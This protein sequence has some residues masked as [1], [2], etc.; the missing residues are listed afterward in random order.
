MSS[1]WGASRENTAQILYQCYAADIYTAYQFNCGVA[2]GSLILGLWHLLGGS[3]FS[4]PP[5]PVFRVK[6]P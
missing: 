3:Q 2:H 5:A 6:T 4:A 1:K